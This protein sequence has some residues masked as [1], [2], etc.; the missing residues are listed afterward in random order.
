MKFKTSVFTFTKSSSC[1]PSLDWRTEPGQEVKYITK[2]KCH[3][4]E[5]QLSQV[6]SVTSARSE[7]VQKYYG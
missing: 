3:F 5:T 7:E 4:Y 1:Q 6:T 2:I